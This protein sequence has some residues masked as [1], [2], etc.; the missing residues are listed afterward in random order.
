MKR[1]VQSVDMNTQS[2]MEHVSVG[3][4]ENNFLLKLIS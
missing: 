2:Q 1:S 3:A 4:L